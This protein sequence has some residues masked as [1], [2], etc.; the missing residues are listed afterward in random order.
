MPIKHSTPI[1]LRVICLHSP[2]ATY[3]GKE[4]F[5]GLQDKSQ[6]LLD[7]QPRDDGAL[8][9]DFELD[10][11]GTMGQGAPDFGGKFAHG[12]PDARFL[13]LS[14]GYPD[15]GKLTWIFR[16]KIPLCDITWETINAVWNG[17]IEG[18]VDGRRVATVPVIGGW[19][20]R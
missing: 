3:E 17:F 2:P 5:F 16:I 1:H 18:T 7:G 13:Y 4:T 9:F 6:A 8:Q 14:Y 11:K 12:T 10:A 15:G 19:L 20:M